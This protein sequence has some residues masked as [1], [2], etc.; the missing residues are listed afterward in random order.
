MAWG[1]EFVQEVGLCISESKLPAHPIFLITDQT[2]AVDLP[3][4]EVIRTDF[5]FG[6]KLRKAEML[7]FLPPQHDSFLFLDS[8]TRVLD[9]ISLGFVKAETHGVAVAPA[10]HFSLNSFF[11]FGRLMNSEQVPRLGQ[12]Q[13]NTGVIFWVRSPS[14]D[15]LMLRWREL[16][17]KHQEQGFSDQP[18]FTLAME[19]LAFSPYTLPATYNCRGFGEQ[20]SGRVRIWHSRHGVPED[21]NEKEHSWPPRRIVGGR[22]VWNRR[23]GGVVRYI[24]RKLRHIGVG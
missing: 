1:E 16:A 18:F 3:G 8:D 6:G 12:M 21:L 14:V 22:V 19:Q 24:R 15:Q 20:M 4:V 11:G 5:V 9:D 7:D 2:T 10:P 13:Y 17:Q 23:S